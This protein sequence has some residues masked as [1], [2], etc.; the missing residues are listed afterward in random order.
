MRCIATALR[1]VHRKAKSIALQSM[2]CNYV[3]SLRAEVVLATL[4][5]TLPGACSF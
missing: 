4:S 1:G 3:L 5:C 2:R